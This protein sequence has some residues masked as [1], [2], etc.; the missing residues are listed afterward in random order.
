[1]NIVQHARVLFVYLFVD[2]DVVVVD[3][4]VVCAF[5]CSCDVLLC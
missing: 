3:D 4:D 2:V 5:V 1:M